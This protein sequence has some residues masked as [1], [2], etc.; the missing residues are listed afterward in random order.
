[1]RLEFYF[2]ADLKKS[3]R[4]RLH[5]HGAL[6][7]V[8]YLSGRG[9]SAVGGTTFRIQRNSF[10]I[11]PAGVYHDQE[12]QTD[13]VS[14]CLGL[15]DSGLESVRGCWCDLD[16]AVHAC[17]RR[18]AD[19]MKKKRPFYDLICRGILDELCGEIKRV[20]SEKQGRPGKGG[21]V[22]RA[23]EIIEEQKGIVSVGDLADQLY[24]SK[25]YLR[26]L[27]LEYTS[28]SP[29][30]H[31]ITAR[32]DKAKDLLGRTDLTVAQVAQACGFENFY[33]FSRLF[34]KET[35]FSPSE[36]RRSMTEK[37]K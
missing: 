24:V 36:Y 3:Y 22:S 18:F 6:E 33:Y 37:D 29:I 12:N 10:M 30:R 34:R 5:T 11:I 2:V 26:H 17:I 32:V 14:F 1:M 9:R 19:E 28:R 4:V 15:A 27:F 35:S 25:D 16:G 8:Y 13:V 31:I 21:L 20:A 7:V 23:L